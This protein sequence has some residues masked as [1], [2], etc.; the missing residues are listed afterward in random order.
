VEGDE[1]GSEKVSEVYGQ[2]L[3][4]CALD[5]EYLL[6]TGD[7]RRQHKVYQTLVVV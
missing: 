7:A 1:L 5:I 4:R 6:S 3:G 2:I